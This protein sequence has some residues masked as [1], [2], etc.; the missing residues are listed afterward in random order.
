M[1]YLLRLSHKPVFTFRQNVRL[2]LEVFAI[3]FL[4]SFAFI[5]LQIAVAPHRPKSATNLELPCEGK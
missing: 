5:A 1:R 2:L 3:A 4:F